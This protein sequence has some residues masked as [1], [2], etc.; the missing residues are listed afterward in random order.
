MLAHFRKQPPSKTTLPIRQPA[1]S[2][3]KRESEVLQLIAKGCRVN[4]VTTL[5]EIADGTVSAHVKK[6]HEKLDVHNRAEATIAAIS[7]NLVSP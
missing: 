2:L 5:L 7:L 1:L 6:I 3:T 4:E